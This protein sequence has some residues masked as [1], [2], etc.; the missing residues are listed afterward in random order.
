MTAGKQ[1]VFGWSAR[2][3]RKGAGNLNNFYD[4]NGD[5]RPTAKM[6]Q[7]SQF[8]PS[9]IKMYPSW[10]GAVQPV[11]LITAI[12][13]VRSSTMRSVQTRVFVLLFILLASSACVFASDPSLDLS[14]YAHTAWKVRE[15]S[16]RGTIFS[17][18]QT[19]DGYLW[20][21][22]EFGL[23]RFDGVQ[24][25]PWQPP[26]GEHLPGNFIQDLLVA[27]DGTLWI[28]AD[29]GLASWKDGKL[30]QYPEFA[31]YHIHS[32]LQDAGGTIW[33]A[34]ENPGR[35]CGVQ[36]GT[37][38][39]RGDGSFGFS[40]YAL[41][42]DHKGNLWVSAQTGLWR[43]S[44]GPPEHYDLPEGIQAADLLEDN[45]AT[46]LMT[47]N[48]SGRFEGHVNGS[49]EG[50]KQFSAGK[51]RDYTLP[52]IAGQFT[53]LRLLRS[54][55]GSL[56][57]G[58]IRGLL[59][60]HQGS[61]DQYSTADGLSGDLVT[62]I[63]EDR[64]GSVW[65]STS[66][67]LDR[68][69][70]L[71]V[72]TISVNQGLSIA[73][74]DVLQAS[75]DGSIWIATAEGLNR[76]RDG[77]M[78]VYGN[79]N[80]PGPN[81]PTDQRPAIVNARVT[82]VPK[83]ALQNK[84][85]SLGLDDR[86]RLW[87]GNSEGVF[88]FDRGRFV[89]VPGLPG[90]DM[91]SIAGDGHGK[92]WISSLDHGLIYSTAEG[93]VQRVPWARFGH[94][95]AAVTLLPD[96]LQGGLWLG[97][98]EGGIA[99]FKD[100]QVRSSYNVANG[101]GA[102]QVNDLQLGSDGAVWAATE[103][104]LSRVKDG[105]ITTLTSKNGLPCD[106]VQGVIEDND[107]SFWLYM[108]CGLVRITRSEL[109][110]WVSDPTRA[111][112][113]NLFDRSDGVW[114][115]GR[116]GS[117]TPYMTKSPD[118]KIWLSAP[119]GASVIDPRHLPFNKLPPPV[120]VTQIIAN[121]RKYDASQG[122]A[123]PARLR[124]LKID[125][126]ALSLV[127]PEK[128]HFRFKLEGQDQDWREVINQRSVEYSNLSPGNYRFSVTACN[129]SG[130]WNEQGAFLDFSVAPAYYQ[131]SWFLALCVA[132]FMA[133]LWGLHELRVRRLSREFNMSLEARVGER[134]RIARELHDT[135][136]QSFH[137]LLLSFQTVSNMLS[138]GR[139]KE[140]LDSAIEQ[141]A[142]AITEGRD[143]VQGLRSST[144][145]TN[146]LAMAIKAI[147]E[148]LLADTTNQNHVEFRV[149]VEGRPRDLHPV[150]RDEVYRIAGEALR[151]AFRH[152]QAQ[153]IEV[154]I[155]YDD[156]Q[157]QL[158]VRDDGKGI[159]SKLLSGVGRPGHFGLHGMRERAKLA[160]GQLMVWSEIDSG[161]EV[162][163]TVPGSQAYEKSPATRRS[164][165]TEKLSQKSAGKDKGMKQ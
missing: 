10:P 106:A 128:M 145:E 58:T 88:Y 163:L 111:I 146:D 140:K 21:G 39:C 82:E 129:N 150:L 116:A 147:G 148:E 15:G 27:R 57:I 25:V 59:H 120:Y 119:D 125:Y 105:R 76:W 48:K 34:A 20:L 44:P 138:P 61:I 64:E 134:T 165:L 127:A 45:N 11:V 118:G 63:F 123:L 158:C 23:A 49:M 38:K 141:A 4:D 117:H 42:E 153:Q 96:R 133:M 67:G 22:T 136:L 24:A 157:L 159:D 108:G 3:H 97:F 102:G 139:V 81:G 7:C 31:G 89:R 29:G 1:F 47:T 54:S 18:A 77:H 154:E 109:D 135:L 110:V 5:L 79:Q 87:A 30:K 37:T 6:A 83:S 8:D 33:F 98:A 143:A 19:P 124:D 162:E 69:R 28:G 113:T 55:D 152:A 50:L 74:A 32:L 43:W 78:T 90:G 93:I 13:M 131:T 52:V 151:N 107:H 142:Q 155:R 132:A 126:T 26:N 62:C 12:L 40:V 60:L 56:W 85:Y 121:G 65:V 86:R 46:L 130:V 92:V 17:I 114:S 164:W 72:P 103:G 35:I 160:G 144:V 68:F 95:Y 104:G 73:A 99:Y 122:S 36:A 53:P 2:V 14:Q 101:L 66:T 75:T 9:S 70:A 161:T 84:V 112:Q 137:G 71:A 156:G 80:V 149:Q 94:N 41:Y 91:F 100:G 16:I 51:I 115:F